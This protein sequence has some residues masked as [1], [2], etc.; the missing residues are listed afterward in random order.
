ME[1]NDLFSTLGI[2]KPNEEPATPPVEEPTEPTVPED[3]SVEPKGDE[4]PTEPEGTEATETQLTH[5][6]KQNKAFAELRVQN[7]QYQKTMQ[8]LGQLLGATQNDPNEIYNIV[9]NQIVQAQAQKQGVPVDLLN[10]INFLEGEYAKNQQEAL[11]QQ[12]LLGFQNIKKQ[13]SLTDKEVDSFADKLVEL[14]V[15]PFEKPV[16]LVSVYKDVFFEN[17]VTKS[18]EKALKEERERASKANNNS[19][20]P[21]TVTGDTKD[22]SPSTIKSAKELDNWFNNQIKK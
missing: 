5:T 10:K 1:L 14:G 19:T 12:A 13:F 21:S 20:S 2:E 3:N 22:I 7:Q 16:N 17:L 6:S 8:A 4:T 11:H 18:V 9:Q 15:N